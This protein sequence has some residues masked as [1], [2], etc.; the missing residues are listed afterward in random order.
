MLDDEIESGKSGQL[1]FRS[2]GSL[3]HSI[4][5]SMPKIYA[6]QTIDI[7]YNIIINK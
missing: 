2:G 4:R 7:V 3:I 6:Y 1:Y 5:L